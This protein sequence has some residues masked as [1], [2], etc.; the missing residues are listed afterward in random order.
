MNLHQFLPRRLP[1][2]TASAR[3][4]AQRNPPRLLSF[5]QSWGDV[6]VAAVR[7]ASL[8]LLALVSFALAAAGMLLVL[9]VHPA[10]A[11]EDSPP[12]KPTGLSATTAHDQVALSWDDPGD[13]SI[14]GYVILRRN[15]E[16]DAK[17]E[18]TELV[19]DTG[20]A[21]TS[22]TDGS[23]AA[24]TRYTYRIKAI[25]EQGVS[26]RSRW[27]HIDTPS[28]PLPAK[29][30][31]LTATATHDQVA[32]TWDDPN[33]DSITGYLILRRDKDIHEEGTFETVES[34]TASAGTTYTDNTVGPERRYVYRIKA[35]NADGVSEISGWVRAYTPEAPEPEPTPE[36]T[37]EEVDEPPAQPTGLSAEVSHDQVALTWDDPNYDSIT[38][39]VILRRNR[40]TAAEG[41]F[42][43]LVED[44]GSAATTYTDDS[45]AAETPYTY[46]IKAINAA[47][48]SERSRWV[49]VDTPAEPTPEPTPPPAPKVSN[50][51]MTYH[52]EDG[53]NWI[54]L[55]WKRPKGDVDG[56]RVL[57]MRNSRMEYSFRVVAEIDDPHV[58]SYQ[59]RDVVEGSDN[60]WVVQAYNEAGFSDY[61]QNRCGYLDSVYAEGSLGLAYPDDARA[62][63]VE[64]DEGP[65]VLVEWSE[66]TRGYHGGE[67]SPVTGYQILRWDINHGFTSWDLL[68]ENT[69]STETSFI[70]RSILPNSRYTYKVRAWNDWG[71]GERSFSAQVRTP[72]WDVLGAPR[73][74]T[75]THV[76]DG[77]RLQWD[78]PEDTDGED[79]LY[80]VYRRANS[81]SVEPLQLLEAGYSDLQFVDNDVVDGVHYHYQVQVDGGDDVTS[82]GMLSRLVA[83]GWD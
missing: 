51:A 73:N 63:F 60:Y 67:V 18:F 31:G 50:N 30:T 69:G 72:D 4:L 20:N 66:P 23:V 36:P 2:V 62:A 81:G 27:F 44:T 75:V 28:V 29:P 10:Y 59:E 78:H 7:P 9:Y 17:G 16:T 58:T 22:Y 47:G 12:A 3:T 38:G 82:H 13:V 76:D 24:E 74:L 83:S 8:P 49:H 42:T 11:Q 57:R 35:I 54:S 71:V 33:D 21:A 61:S 79:M 68:V 45:V 77:I 70:D 46:R 32:L 56:Y 52:V 1:G 19:S 41:E 6:K 25:N 39:Y 64:D 43:T 80:R 65:G 15:R 48:T 53:Q 14:T 40:D 37:P 5:R 55:Q 34:D 26:E